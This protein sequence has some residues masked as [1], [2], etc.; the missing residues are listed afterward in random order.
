MPTNIAKRKTVQVACT[1]LYPLLL[2][3]ALISDSKLILHSQLLQIILI[4]RKL[5][6]S[7]ST[8]YMSYVRKCTQV[9]LDL[10]HWAGQAEEEK[11]VGGLLTDRRGRVNLMWW[12]LL[13]VVLGLVATGPSCFSRRDEF[14]RLQSILFVLQCERRRLCLAHL[15]EGVVHI[16]V[17]RLVSEHASQ[18]IKKSGVGWQHPV[19]DGVLWGRQVCPGSVQLCAFCLDV[20]DDIRIGVT[21]RLLQVANEPMHGI[22]L[23]RV[24]E[25]QERRHRQL[26]GDD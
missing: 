13:V 18:C 25:H 6:F 19:G 11:E 2:W 22:W 7:T 21:R 24:D 14:V 5:R 10:L 4:R 9:R 26:G 8:C 1:L 23:D 17:V 12:L 15:C 3:S 16:P 20:L